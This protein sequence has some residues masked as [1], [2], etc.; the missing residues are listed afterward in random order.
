M[1]SSDCWIVLCEGI[2][3]SLWFW[4]GGFKLSLK[5]FGGVVGLFDIKH[6][7]V[8]FLVVALLFGTKRIR[9]LGAD[10]GGCIKSF[11]K[12]VD[13]CDGAEVQHSIGMSSGVEGNKGCMGVK[14]HS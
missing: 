14:H 6:W 1:V 4:V 13:E 5:W 9:G 3:R 7:L 12:S 10:L 11:R 8:V 2:W